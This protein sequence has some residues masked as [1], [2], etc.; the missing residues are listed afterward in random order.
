VKVF[1]TLSVVNNEFESLNYYPNPVANTLYI[2]NSEPIKQ[3]AVYNLVGQLLVQQQVNESEFSLDLNELPQSIYIV[4]L[5]TE[6]QN[7]NFQ[8]IKP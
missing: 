1:I 8:V 4:K 3:V 2:S 5:E 7:I 6:K